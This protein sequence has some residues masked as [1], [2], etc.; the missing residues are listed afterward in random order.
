MISTFIYSNDIIESSLY[1]YDEDFLFYYVC[2]KLKE[3]GPSTIYEL[4]KWIID[5]AKISNINNSKFRNFISKFKQS[6]NYYYLSEGEISCLE[7]TKQF[8]SDLF[9]MCFDNKDDLYKSLCSFIGQTPFNISRVLPYLLTIHKIKFNY[10]DDFYFSCYFNT[11]QSFNNNYLKIDSAVSNIADCYQNFTLDFIFADKFLLDIFFANGINTVKD[12]S[13][14]SVESL[15]VIFSVNLKENIKLLSQLSM[16]FSITYKNK[17]LDLYNSLNDREKE[18]LNLRK[19]FI[20]GKKYVLEEIGTKLDL[21]RER[22]RQIEAKATEK[23][24]KDNKYLINT[25]AGLYFS[26]IKSGQKYITK[27]RIDEYINDSFISNILLFILSNSE[28]AIKYDTDLEIMYNSNVT[29]I[30]E[31]VDEIVDAYGDIIIQDD[32]NCLDEFEKK[33]VKQKYRPVIDDTVFLLRGIPERRLM[34]TIIEDLFPHGYHISDEKSFEEAKNEYVKRYK[35]WNDNIDSR[36]V[37]TYLERDDFCQC[38][39]GTYISRNL[40]VKIPSSLLDRIINYITINQPSVF[41]ESVFTHFK[42]ELIPLGINNYYYLKGIIDPYLP[43]EFNTKRNYIQTGAIKIS[44]SESIIQFM[45]SFNTYFTLDD[46]RYKFEGV[47]DYTLYNMLYYELDNGLVWVSSKKFI[48]LN[49]IGIGDTEK[50]KFYE[51][52]RNLYMSL[53]TKVLSARKIYSRLA[54]TNRELLNKLNIVNDQFSLF[55]LIRALY[56]DEFYYNRPIIAI[57]EESCN[58]QEILIRDYVSKL[59][60]FNLN[61]VKNYISKLSLRGLY[62]YLDFM[63]DMSDEFVQIN[64]DTMIKKEL[65]GFIEIKKKEFID[66]F[67]LIFTKFE[68]VDTRT[69]NGYAMLPS[70]EYKWNKYLLVGVIRSFFLNQFEIQNTDNMYNQTDFII[71]KI[72]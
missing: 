13:E 45:Q 46:L 4:K 70:L 59:E 49:K 14:L 39:K 25:F 32:Y 16:N 55:S 52:I 1:Y 34:V 9:F 58:S 29:S 54:F 12:L 48:Y 38:D 68:F 60:K 35:V 47:K 7:L 51:F 57:D 6:G 24:C 40:A 72:R 11:L 5:R 15:M 26:I 3:K 37:A 18:I 30:N 63:E 43:D 42:N 19:A 17:V 36:I 61:I 53:N 22:V 20:D 71:K 41:Y 27:N 8:E 64:I 50:K 23:L 62:S 66:L 69:F 2:K 31:I 65:L 44:S 10:D 33:I 28:G 67:D 56:R 21:T